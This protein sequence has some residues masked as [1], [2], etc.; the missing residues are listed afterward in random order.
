MLRDKHFCGDRKHIVE[1]GFTAVSFSVEY[2][3]LVFGL[4]FK[5]SR[6]S[7]PSCS[8]VMLCEVVLRLACLLKK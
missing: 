2:M 3:R 8:F 7:Y 5:S 1:G 6:F 4:S